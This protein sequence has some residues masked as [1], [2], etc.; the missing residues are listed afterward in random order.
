MVR[1][2]ILPVYNQ[3]VCTYARDTLHDLQSRQID[4]LLTLHN[5]L[6]V[7]K[8][9]RTRVCPVCTLHNWSTAAG[10][11]FTRLFTRK[12]LWRVCVVSKLHSVTKTHMRSYT[13]NDWRRAR[14][15]MF[16]FQKMDVHKKQAI[17]VQWFAVIKRRRKRWLLCCRFY[18]SPMFPLTLCLA[19]SFAEVGRHP[20][21]QSQPSHN[22]HSTLHTTGFGFRD[23]SG[24][25]ECL[26]SFGRL[27]GIGE[28]L[29]S[30][31]WAA[32]TWDWLRVPSEGRL[33]SDLGLLSAISKKRVENQD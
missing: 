4:V 2:A 14:Y 6:S 7:I 12:N 3:C 13:G 32:H 29:G 8:G 17:H 22:S 10:S 5:L 21:C 26:I 20:H 15:R 11:Y 18:N 19:R 31:L 25:L 24:Y 9:L 16:F 33:A 27:R 1:T 28:F 23:R 30:C